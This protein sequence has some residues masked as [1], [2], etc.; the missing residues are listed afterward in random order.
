MDRG[1]FLYRSYF[2]KK[3]KQSLRKKQSLFPHLY[4]FNDLMNCRTLMEITE[5][6]LPRYSSYPTSQAYFQTYTLAG[7]R[8]SE[9]SV[10]LLVLTAADDPIIPVED[11][12]ALEGNQCLRIRVERH[13]GHCGF[14]QDYLLRSWSQ[15][16]IHDT[17]LHSG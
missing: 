7:R 2:L 14:L 12:L 16:L 3:W 9:L 5:R 4:D 13:G 15:D 11:F 17:L 1:F 6:I 8:F 10:P